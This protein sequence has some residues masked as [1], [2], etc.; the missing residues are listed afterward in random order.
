[1]FFP[2]AHTIAIV[3]GTGRLGS[4]LAFRWARAGENVIIGSRD[5]PRAESVAAKISAQGVS[6][7]SLQGAENAVA[8]ASSDVVVLTVPF[9][10]HA[11]LLKQLHPAFRPG[12]VLIDATV[13][14]VAGVGGRSTRALAMG[15]G[16]AAQQAAELVPAGVVVAA[17]FQ[18][19]SAHQLG[20]DRPVECDVV[21]CTDDLRA[22]QIASGLAEEIPG[23]RAI[24]GGGLENAR[25]LEQ[26]TALLIALNRKYRVHAA[27]L[28]FTGLPIGDPEK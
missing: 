23:V 21:V 9:E 19:L 26:I 4:A 10:G 8:V 16:S 2:L 6:A 7:G 12:T 27:G 22:R 20:S 3:G 5:A 1:M 15:Q 13:P 28:R 24:D 18:N 25:I 11:E 14:L 17:A